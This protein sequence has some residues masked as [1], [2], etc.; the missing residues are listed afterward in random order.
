MFVFL[1]L[2]AALSIGSIAALV[3]VV[4]RDGYRRVPERALVR[5]L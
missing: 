2:L 5:I 3:P 1:A 4:S